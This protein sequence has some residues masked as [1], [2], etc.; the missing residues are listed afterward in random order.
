M[1]F[2]DSKDDDNGNTSD[3]QEQE[4][5]LIQLDLKRCPSVQPEK[6]EYDDFEFGENRDRS[7]VRL[8]VPTRLSILD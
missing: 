2:G 4:C 5:K 1:K 6:I 3:K 8:R 7:I